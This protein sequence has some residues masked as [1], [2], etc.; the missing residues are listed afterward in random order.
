MDLT[1]A[2]KVFGG[3]QIEINLIGLKIARYQT[4]L[5]ESTVILVCKFKT[6]YAIMLILQR[7][8]YTYLDWT[9]LIAGKITSGYET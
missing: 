9:F 1:S 3:S 6:F 8:S 4:A 2:I 5:I 7:E